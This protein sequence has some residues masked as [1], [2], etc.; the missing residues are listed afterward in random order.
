M[1]RREGRLRAAL[2]R[3]G[4]DP[5]RLPNIGCFSCGAVVGSSYAQGEPTRGSPGERRP[6]DMKRGRIA[7][8]LLA[9]LMLVGAALLLGVSHKGTKNDHS[10]FAGKTSDDPDESWKKDSA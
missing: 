3:S 7:L 10:D 8:G 1:A 5:S 9:L 2:S 4:A 6:V